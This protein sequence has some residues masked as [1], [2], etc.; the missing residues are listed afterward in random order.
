[1][2]DDDKKKPAPQKPIE[3]R[4]EKKPAVD[5]TLKSID[6]GVF[7][8]NKNL[9]SLI[10]KTGNASNRAEQRADLLLQAADAQ[11]K[12]DELAENGRAKDAAEM[13][14]AL[15][16][17]SRLLKGSKTDIAI[18]NRLAELATINSNTASLIEKYG[19]KEEQATKANLAGI[20]GVIK[21]IERQ[22]AERPKKD[23]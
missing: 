11:K 7:D 9:D 4:K 22:T 1:M 19:T 18:G 16:E 12:I 8:A 21:R 13:Q 23:F 10:A 17:T 2:A 20:Q 6:D 15:D 5:P 3:K 14:K